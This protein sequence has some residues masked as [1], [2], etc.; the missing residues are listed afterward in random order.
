MRVRSFLFL[1][2]PLSLGA[3]IQQSEYAARRTALAKLLGNGIVVAIG[4]PESEQDYIA[5]NQNSP[6][7]YLTGFREPDAGLVFEVKNGQ[8]VGTEKLFVQPSDP[9]REVWTGKRVG[10]PA[11]QPTLGLEGRDE[12]TLLKVIDSL[13]TRDSTATLNVIGDFEPRRA[14]LGSTDQQIIELMK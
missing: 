4:S 14:I 1:C 9:S 2:L 8:I 12:G 5:F 3:Q 7:V 10:V 13:L 11:V 6:F